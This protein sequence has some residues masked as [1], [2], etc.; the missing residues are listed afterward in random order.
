M[1]PRLP[2]E[3]RGI[4]IPEVSG[5]RPTPGPLYIPQSSPWEVP[6]PGSTRFEGQSRAS[7]VGSLIANVTQPLARFTIP[8][9][10]KGI[11]RT[12]N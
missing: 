11:I 10:M 6:P 3:L 2:K 4:D 1:A 8:E 5:P 9:G 12:L 7:V